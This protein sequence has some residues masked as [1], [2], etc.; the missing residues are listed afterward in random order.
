MEQLNSLAFLE[1][2]VRE[3]LRINSVVQNSVRVAVQDDSIPLSA[4]VV[5]RNGTLRTEIKSVLSLKEH[6]YPTPLISH[7][8]SR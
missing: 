1:A 3:T 8:Q 7:H 4:P 2:V 5:D 6:R